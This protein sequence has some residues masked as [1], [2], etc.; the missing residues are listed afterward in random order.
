MAARGDG[1]VVS[2]AEG[3]AGLFN[4]SPSPRKRSV[5]RASE[6]EV[7]AVCVGPAGEMFVA[8][9]RCVRPLA[10]P[11]PA[12][13]LELAASREGDV[14]ALDDRGRIL[15]Y[16]GACGRFRPGIDEGCLGPW[17][18]AAWDDLETS[19]LGAPST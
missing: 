2:F 7:S 17:T 15:R 19:V 10:E 12:R 3:T 16:A 9:G 14:Y 8:S 5:W 11:A 18:R 6:D 1:F 4:Y 13:V